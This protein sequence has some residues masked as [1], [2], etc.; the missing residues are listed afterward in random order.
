MSCLLLGPQLPL[1][2]GDVTQPHGTRCQTPAGAST[3]RPWYHGAVG[4]GEQKRMGTTGVTTQVAC[5]PM[6]ACPLRRLTGPSST[7]V[8]LAAYFFATL[9]FKKRDFILY[10]VNL[11]STT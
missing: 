2:S 11:I 9:F 5:S 3:K 8:T 7:P 4:G 10:N 6:L 1:P